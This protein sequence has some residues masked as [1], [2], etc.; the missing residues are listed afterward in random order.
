[1]QH[2]GAIKAQKN[3]IFHNLGCCLCLYFSKTL[4]GIGQTND[5]KTLG[6]PGVLVGHR[7]ADY[8]LQTKYGLHPVFVGKDLL[9]HSQVHSF[10]YC[11]CLPL[12][13]KVAELNSFHRACIAHKAIYNI[14][15]LYFSRK[16]CQAY[17]SPKGEVF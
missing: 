6:S 1:M 2:K 8:G 11:L 12:F 16:V 15:F 5:L 9:E 10:N 17:C 13:C 3:A 14:Y 7:S 4:L